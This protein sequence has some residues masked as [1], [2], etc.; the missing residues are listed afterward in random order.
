[1]ADGTSL[2]LFLF[3][4]FGR[5]LHSRVADAKIVSLEIPRGGI[6]YRRLCTIG[7]FFVFFFFSFLLSRSNVVK[8]SSETGE[9][10]KKERLWHQQSEGGKQRDARKSLK[11]RV[12]AT[13]AMCYGYNVV[14]YLH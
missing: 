13:L 3:E 9:K 5:Y 2:H 4:T 10:K 1:M 14:E 11:K 12:L 6:S 8:I 7:L